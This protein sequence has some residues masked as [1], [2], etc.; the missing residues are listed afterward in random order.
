MEATSAPVLV[1]LGRFVTTCGSRAGS[2]GGGGGLGV[3]RLFPVDL[4]GSAAEDIDCAG[5][6]Y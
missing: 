5:G 4:R 2:G 3:P 1:V 6:E